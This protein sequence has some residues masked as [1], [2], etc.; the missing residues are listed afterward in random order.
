MWDDPFVVYRTTLFIALTAYYVLTT[1][2]A[3]VRVAELLRGTDPRRRLLRV[4][5]SYQLATIRVRPLASELIQIL[6]LSGL[7]VLIWQLH[8]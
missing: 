1:T 2:V 5:L 4:Y 6:L 3:A 8:V 7:L